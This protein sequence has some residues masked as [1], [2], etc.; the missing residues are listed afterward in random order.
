[1]VNWINYF[2]TYKKLTSNKFNN[3]DLIEDMNLIKK[4]TSNEILIK[5]INK[6]IGSFYEN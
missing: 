1:M 3:N 4:N 5:L 6:N 2:S